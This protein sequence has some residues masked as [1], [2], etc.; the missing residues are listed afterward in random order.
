[1]A[2]QSRT[3][4]ILRAT[5]DGDEYTKTPQSREEELL[6]E[7]KRTIEGGGGGGGASVV[8]NPEGEATETLTKLGVNDTVY[9]IPSGGSNRTIIECVNKSGAIYTI[10][11]YTRHDI[12]EMLQSG[13]D[14]VLKLKSN[15]INNL[16]QYFYLERYRSNTSGDKYYYIFT[17]VGY[18]GTNWKARKVEIW[19]MNDSEVGLVGAILTTN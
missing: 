1:M 17:N 3:E 11:N 12:Y 15:S 18:D 2:E 9:G 7:L 4:E 14:I 6:L 10:Q 5:I 16:E 19:D 8:P 13:M